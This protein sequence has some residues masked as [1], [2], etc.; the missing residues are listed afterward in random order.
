MKRTPATT[1]VRRGMVAAEA[2]HLERIGHAAA[3]LQCKV[4]Q[5]TVDVV[6][7]DEHR[8]ARVEFARDLLLQI[9][10]SEDRR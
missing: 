10:F 2:R 5:V 6:V 7:G 8:V 9:L 1:S 4:L 3:G